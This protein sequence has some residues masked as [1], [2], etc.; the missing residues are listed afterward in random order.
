MLK[1]KKDE[2]F[3]MEQ[4]VSMSDFPMHMDAE[5]IST[6]QPRGFFRYWYRA[7][8]GGGDEFDLEISLSFL[9]NG[10]EYH[11]FGE[12]RTLEYKDVELKKGMEDI[13]ILPDLSTLQFDSLKVKIEYTPDKDNKEMQVGPAE[14]VIDM[15]YDFGCFEFK[16]EIPTSPITDIPDVVTPA[17]CITK[18]LQLDPTL[19]IAGIHAGDQCICGPS[20]PYHAL[21]SVPSENETVSCSSMCK[22]SNEYVCGGP[23]AVSIYAG[24]CEEGKVRFGDHCFAAGKKYS[25]V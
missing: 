13:H 20:I 16:D 21:Y 24:K 4:S 25:R 5:Y 9:E 17:W 10:V 2:T 15:P 14:V 6:V 12:S 7:N 23:N 8:Q 19:I 22:G 11:K 3:K 18:C 1:C